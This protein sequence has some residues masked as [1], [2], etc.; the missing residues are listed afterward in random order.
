MT[1]RNTVRFDVVIPVYNEESILEDQIRKLMKTLEGIDVSFVIFFAENGSTDNT[2]AILEKLCQHS[3]GTMHWFHLKEP[4]YGEALK[5]GYLKT[6][7]DHVVSIAVDF[8][9]EEFFRTVMERYHDADIIQASKNLSQ[10]KD[11]RQLFRKILSF[12]LTFMIK[13]F[14]DYKGTDTHGIRYI[15]APSVMPVVRKCTSSYGIFDTE[16]ILR[17][18][19]EGL[20]II[21]IPFD[22]KE[23]RKQRNPMILKIVRNVYR[24]FFVILKLRSEYRK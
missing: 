7:S 19:K 4:N 21:E 11:Q 1:R 13:L 15:H 17:C 23:I 18:E 22:I 2:P 8:W 12:G 3:K 9:S 10:S 5:Q 6:E 16:L 24:L 20:H 14:V